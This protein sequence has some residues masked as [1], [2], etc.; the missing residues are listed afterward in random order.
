MIGIGKEGR[1]EKKKDGMVI[2]NKPTNGKQNEGCFLRMFVPTFE[3]EFE[4]S[5]Q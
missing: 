5:T 2:I 4:N 3:P 1:K